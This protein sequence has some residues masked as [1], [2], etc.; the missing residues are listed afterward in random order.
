MQTLV[1]GSVSAFHFLLVWIVLIIIFYLRIRGAA[2]NVGA[3]TLG[4]YACMQG[5]G[6]V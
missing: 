2:G 3:S 5:D 6:S 4:T 1:L